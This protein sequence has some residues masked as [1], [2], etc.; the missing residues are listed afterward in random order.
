[1]SKQ[2]FLKGEEVDGYY[3]DENMKKFWLSEHDILEKLIAVCKKYNLKYCKNLGTE[4]WLIIICFQN[5][6]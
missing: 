4:S 6:K 5:I 1:M 3:I 2:R